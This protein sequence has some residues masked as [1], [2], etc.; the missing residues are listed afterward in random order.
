MHRS[1]GSSVLDHPICVVQQTRGNHEPELDRCSRG[2][3][4][5]PAPQA[6]GVYTSLL[7]KRQ[8]PVGFG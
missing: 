6:G 7:V 1:S 5:E 8:L 4:T 2:S 3:N